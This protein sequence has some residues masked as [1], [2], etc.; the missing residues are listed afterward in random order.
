MYACAVLTFSNDDDAVVG[1]GL[2]GFDGALMG[3][4]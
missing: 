1:V 2:N 3:Y 4:V